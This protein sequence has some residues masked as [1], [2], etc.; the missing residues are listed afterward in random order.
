MNR[1]T[2]SARIMVA[3][4]GVVV[5]P[6]ATLVEGMVQH[7]MA[8][9]VAEIYASFDLGIAR[10]DFGSTSDTVRRLTGRQPQSAGEFLTANRVALLG[11]P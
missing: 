8:R 10:G 1:V 9:P 4:S 6:F 11:A 3:R 2:T 7:G 5:T